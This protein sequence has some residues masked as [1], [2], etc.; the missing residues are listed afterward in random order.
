M[1]R[2]ARYKRIKAFDP[3][4]K[5][6]P[7]VPE[8]GPPKNLAPKNDPD[9][10]PHKLAELMRMQAAAKQA[11]QVATRSQAPPA[12]P[13]PP[14]P[15]DFYKVDGTLRLRFLQPTLSHIPPLVSV[16]D[17]VSRGEPEIF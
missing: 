9:V 11:N 4:A 6:R 3:G 14:A 13:P 8:K 5:R 1:G 12:Q 17:A 10:I 2:V 7:A 16:C 15:H